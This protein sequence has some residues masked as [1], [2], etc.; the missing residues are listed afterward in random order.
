MK[1]RLLLLLIFILFLVCFPVCKGNFNVFPLELSITMS[2]EFIKGNTSKRVLITNNIE[3][4]INISWY[5]DNPTLDLIRENKTIIPYLD[6]ISIE[7][8][9][10]VIQP[11]ENTFFYIYLDIP[12]S[13]QNYNQHWEVWPT[14]KNEETQFFNLEHSVRLY[15]DTPAEIINDDEGNIFD[16]FNIQNSVLILII[17]IAALTLF[18]IIRKKI[19]KK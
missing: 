14:F 10:Q 5:L 8:K 1:K 18:F 7:P 15:I 19:Y 11:Y 2:N 9:W 12:D 4:S 13:P 6:W 16:F 17:M 3:K